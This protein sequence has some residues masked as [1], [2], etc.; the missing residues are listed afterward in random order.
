[1]ILVEDDADNG[2]VLEI[3][4]TAE[5]ASVRR[6]SRAEEALTLCESAPPSV[7]L[8]DIVLPEQD[9]VWLLRQ[10]SGLRG[11]RIPVVAVT[12]RAFPH[13]IEAMTAAGFDRYLVKPADFEKVVDVILELAKTR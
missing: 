7:V 13:E 8:T 5:G 2:E 12:G 4:L 10:I 9:G 11:P 1:M 6:A 3:A